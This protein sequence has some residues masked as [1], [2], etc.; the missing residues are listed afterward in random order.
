MHI[1]VPLLPT[2]TLQI[3][4]AVARG[5]GRG[6]RKASAYSISDFEL[7]I[8]DFVVFF[9]NPHSAID[10]PQ[11]HGPTGPRNESCLMVS[12]GNALDPEPE[13]ASKTLTFI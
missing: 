5:Q 6:P 8:S 2:F 7:W 4:F 12:A 10:I 13:K 9:F 1:P 11:C 3:S